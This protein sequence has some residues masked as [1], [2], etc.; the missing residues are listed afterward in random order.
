MI[1][2]VLAMYF[3]FTCGKRLAYRLADEVHVH[4]LVRMLDAL[5]LL[6]SFVIDVALLLL[7]LQLRLVLD[8]VDLPRRLLT[9]PVILEDVALALFVHGHRVPLLVVFDLGNDLNFLLEAFL[10]LQLPLFLLLPLLLLMFE[11]QQ[12]LRVVDF[13]AHLLNDS[14]YYLFYVFNR[15]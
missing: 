10:H 6:L 1:F 8:L 14:R 4:P 15:L 2:S 12:L 5:L 3:F 13:S 7:L 9:I 11:P